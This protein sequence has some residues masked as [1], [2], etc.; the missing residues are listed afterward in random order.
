MSAASDR[1]QMRL[2]FTLMGQRAFE[3]AF[4]RALQDTGAPADLEWLCQAHDEPYIRLRVDLSHM[5]EI[6]LRD[7]ELSLMTAV[8]RLFEDG[9]LADVCTDDSNAEGAGNGR[10]KG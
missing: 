2:M 7:S 10:S 1:E 3:G 5:L 9:Y 6:Y 4:F 8:G